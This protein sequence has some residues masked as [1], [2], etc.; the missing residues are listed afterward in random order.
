MNL[1]RRVGLSQ[2]APLVFGVL[3]TATAWTRKVNH[4]RQ[5]F[6]ELRDQVEESQFLTVLIGMPDPLGIEL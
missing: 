2:S 3:V 1:S 5:I 6:E 4:T